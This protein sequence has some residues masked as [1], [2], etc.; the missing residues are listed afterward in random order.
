MAEQRAEIAQGGHAG[1]VALQQVGVAQ[2]VARQ[3]RLVVARHG[4]WTGAAAGALV[5]APRSF[6]LN[7][8]IVRHHLM[9]LK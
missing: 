6:L 9:P 3:Q 5:P 4:M 1:T 2:G 7:V 8:A